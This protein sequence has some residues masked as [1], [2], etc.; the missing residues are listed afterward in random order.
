MFWR[1]AIQPWACG[2][3][4][5]FPLKSKVTSSLTVGGVSQGHPLKIVRFVTFPPHAQFKWISQ[6]YHRF[7]LAL[8]LTWLDFEAPHGERGEM[9]A[10]F[11]S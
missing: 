5:V 8:F 4:Y 6:M 10:S 7:I 2:Y 1:K 11:K 9:R 3:R